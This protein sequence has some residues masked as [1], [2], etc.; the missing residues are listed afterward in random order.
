MGVA[1]RD[2]REDRVEDSGPALECHCS[3]IPE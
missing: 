1:H 2:A 3:A